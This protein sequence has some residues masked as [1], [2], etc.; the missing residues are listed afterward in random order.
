MTQTILKDSTHKQQQTHPIQGKLTKEQEQT[1]NLLHFKQGLNSDQTNTT[2]ITAKID[3][4]ITAFLRQKAQRDL[5]MTT[6]SQQLQLTL[7][8]FAIQPTHSNPTH[9]NPIPTL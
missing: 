7:Q 9:P 1:K 8:P 5:H 3:N 4:T 2:I 6:Q